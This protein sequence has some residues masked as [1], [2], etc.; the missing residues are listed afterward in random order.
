MQLVER[1]II[2]RNDRR[3]AVIDQAAWMAKNIYNAANY[4][5]RQA[6]FTNQQ[7]LH[8]GAI[9][10]HFKKHDLLPDQQLPL[11]VVQQ[12]LKQVDHDWQVLPGSPR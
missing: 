4:R 7:Y 5:V 8:Y 3:W 12:V 11:K 2:D 10:K 9:E 6:F 1:H